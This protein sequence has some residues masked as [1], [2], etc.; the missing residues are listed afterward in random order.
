MYQKKWERAYAILD[1]VRKEKNSRVY[2]CPQLGNY[3]L[4]Y[5]LPIYENAN[6]EYVND[7]KRG[8]HKA[9]QKCGFK[10]GMDGG[11]C[12]QAIKIRTIDGGIIV[13]SDPDAQMVP[14]ARF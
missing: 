12:N 3:A 1:K 2:L 9:R 14:M 11:F 7:I 10:Q 6:I 8:Q 4:K 5:N 13:P